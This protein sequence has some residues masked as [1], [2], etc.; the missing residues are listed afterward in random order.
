MPK[1]GSSFGSAP[2]PIGPGVSAT[3]AGPFVI[4]G[5]IIQGMTGSDD[6]EP[7]GCFITGHDAKTG[8]ELWRVYTIAHPGDPDF[9][10][11]H[12]LPLQG[13]FGAPAWI[14]GS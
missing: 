9:D 7:G 1:A 12:C 11:G 8:A 6:A 2:P 13:R 3:R 5:K 10:T 4:N 14:T